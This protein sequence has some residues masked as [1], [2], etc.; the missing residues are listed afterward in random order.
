[1]TNIAGSASQAL[2]D[3]GTNGDVTAGDNIFSYT[4]TVGAVSAGVKGDSVHGAGQPVTIF[5]GFI[6]LERDGADSRGEHQ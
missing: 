3:A 5:R 2:S 1:M 6:Q 4:A